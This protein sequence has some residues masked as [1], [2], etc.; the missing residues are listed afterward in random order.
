MHSVRFAHQHCVRL[1]MYMY[2]CVYIYILYISVYQH[3]VRLHVYLYICVYM[4]IL[5]IYMNI[6]VYIYVYIC[7]HIII[8]NILTES[9]LSYNGIY[10][11]AYIRAIIMAHIYAII[12]IRTLGV[13]TCHYNGT[14]MCH[15]R[16]THSGRVYVISRECT[17]R[18]KVFIRYIYISMFKWY[19]IIEKNTCVYTIQYSVYII[20]PP[21]IHT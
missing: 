15:Y 6:C 17:M 14:H 5:Y 8:Q 9:A 18:F 1:Y 10:T 2:I 4:Y 11:C 13:F 20:T 19:H 21:Y 16:N 3:C 7:A 12:I